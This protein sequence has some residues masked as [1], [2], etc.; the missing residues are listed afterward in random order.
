MNL[1]SVLFELC[2]AHGVSGSESAVFE[3]VKKHLKTE[4]H[5]TGSSLTASAL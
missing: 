4:T 2:S 3:V 5:V 1:E